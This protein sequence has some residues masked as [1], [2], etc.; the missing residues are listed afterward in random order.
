MILT[1]AVG[2]CGTDDAPTPAEVAACERTL[3]G[4]VDEAVSRQVAAVERATAEVLAVGTASTDERA[5]ATG[6]RNTAQMRASKV[7]SV[8]RRACAQRPRED[9]RIA[10]CASQSLPEVEAV[11]GEPSTTVAGSAS[12]DD[13]TFAVVAYCANNRDEAAPVSDAEFQRCAFDSPNPFVMAKGGCSE[14]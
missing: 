2:G 5:E 14:E 7:A 6:V 11:V 3:H 1:L 4:A 10:T 13:L 9:D 8:I 12:R